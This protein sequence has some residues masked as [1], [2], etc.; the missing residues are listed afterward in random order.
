LPV[1]PLEEFFSGK[2]LQALAAV[3]KFFDVFQDLLFVK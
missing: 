3:G 1:V 2:V